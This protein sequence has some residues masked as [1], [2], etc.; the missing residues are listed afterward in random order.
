MDK[1]MHVAI[2]GGTGFVG[3]HLVDAFIGAGH[4]LS[5]LVRPGSENRITRPE[6]CRIVRGDLSS[7]VCVNETLKNCDAAIYNVGILR[8]FPSKGI[9]FEE[10]HYKCAMRVTELAHALGVS[11]FILMSANGVRADGTPYQRTKFRAEQGALSSGLDA[12]I[13][14]PSV[15]FG[16][17]S[18][19]QEFASQLYR[20]MVSPP[21]PAI[22]LY[23]ANGSGNTVQMSPVHVEDVAAAFVAALDDP[24]T[25]GQTYELGGPEIL[26]WEQILKRIADA[27][28]H[29]KWIIPMPIGLM[30]IP[31]A[32]LDWLPFF[33]VTLD[34]LRML[35]EGNTA[36]PG[37]LTALIGREPRAFDGENLAYLH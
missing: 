12:T 34:Q 37:Q 1:S 17:P 24:S 10:M 13:I 33:P 7:S 16:D 21:L 11:R 9:T 29:N 22:G 14:R 15:I 5:L 3:R 19:R 4:Q 31:T 2:I 26:S 27:T 30:K 23:S 6:R 18:G 36:D 32:L 8:E 35:E 28:G 25:I 20:Q